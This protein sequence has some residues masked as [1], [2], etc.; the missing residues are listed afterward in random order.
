MG[1]K[2]VC[3]RFVLQWHTSGSFFVGTVL[4]VYHVLKINVYNDDVEERKIYS[5][6]KKSSQKCV[7]TIHIILLYIM[8]YKYHFYVG[9]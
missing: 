3:C 2:Q 9:G 1:R 6:N 7:N 5:C 8:L 4:F